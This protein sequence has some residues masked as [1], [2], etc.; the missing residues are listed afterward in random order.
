MPPLLPGAAYLGASLLKDPDLLWLSG[1]ALER[2]VQRGGTLPAQPGVETAVAFEGRSPSQGSCLLYADSGLPN[3]V[4]PLA[5]DKIVFRGGWTPDAAYALLNLRFSGWHR[6]R[7]TNALVTLREGE[8]LVEEKT[9]RPFPW[10]PLERRIFRDK[11]VPREFLNG[12]LVEKTGF[13]AAVER[14]TGFGGPWAQDPP[15]FA[16]VEAFVP[17]AER[18]RSVTSLAGWRGWSQRRT[19]EFRHDG[20]V[21]VIDEADGPPERRAAVAWHVRGRAAPGDRIALDGGAELVLV[22]LEEPAGSVE[23]L[24]EAAP[25]G[26]DLLYR[27]ARSGRLRLASVFLP[28]PWSGAR[29]AASRAPRA[30]TISAGGESLSIPLP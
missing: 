21:V 20:P 13:A 5:P 1:R 22:P 18:D 7:A 4:G 6:Y 8:R 10:L 30:L 27:P 14:L 28:R 9:G 17:G 15:F 12:L 23:R 11:R 3:R 26:M 29:V 16:R 24:G 2:S 25:D 19:I